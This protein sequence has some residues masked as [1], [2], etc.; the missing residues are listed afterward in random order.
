MSSAATRLS[1]IAAR[2]AERPATIRRDR[3]CDFRCQPG[4]LH[5]RQPRSDQRRALDHDSDHDAVNGHARCLLDAGS[6]TRSPE[7]ELPTAASVPTAA[8]APAPSSATHRCA[9][10]MP[11]A[12]SL[13]D[14]IEP[15][16]GVRQRRGAERGA[17]TGSNAHRPRDGSAE[18][19]N[20][21][22]RISVVD[23]PARPRRC[24]LVVGACRIRAPTQAASRGSSSRRA[25]RGRYPAPR[26]NRSIPS[27]ASTWSKVDCRARPGTTRQLP[28]AA[29]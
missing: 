10:T 7:A 24:H 6:A 25:R 14:A 13:P 21:G 5:S 2:V 17:G 4:S 19:G 18:P 23:S 3:G 28:F 29:R 12:S 27:P 15:L 16:P 8:P 26:V 9:P 11:R 1:G 22:A 20:D